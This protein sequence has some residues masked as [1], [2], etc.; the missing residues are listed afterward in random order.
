MILT[1]QCP[2]GG[3]HFRLLLVYSRTSKCVWDFFIKGGKKILLSL[4]S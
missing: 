3:I 1:L 4:A 2:H